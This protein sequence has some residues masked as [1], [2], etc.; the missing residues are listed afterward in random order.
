MGILS[1]GF[2]D[3][4][5]AIIA[6]I[7]CITIH[8]ASHAFAAYKLGDNMA[9]ADGRISLNP[10]RHVDWIGL[11]CLVVF[12]FGWGRSVQANPMN[13]RDPKRGMAICAAAGPLSNLVTAF[14]ATVIYFA[15]LRFAPYNDFAYT[16][17]DILW[18]FIVYSISLGLFNLIPL[19]PLD[20]SKILMMFLPYRAVDFINRTQHLW[21]IILIVL[22]NK[23]VFGDMLSNGV[24][25][26]LSIFESI[27]SFIFGFS[28]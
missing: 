2:P 9:M 25:N 7:L 17:L 27:C 1:Y 26:I 13:F 4:L 23:S 6:I 11:L 12:G 14:L 22:M 18:M 8:E 16:M 5:Y 15:L 19:P 10:F 3:A 24:I 21:F 20:G 28:V